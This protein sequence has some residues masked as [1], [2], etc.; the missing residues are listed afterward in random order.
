[1]RKRSFAARAVVGFVAAIAIA[2]TAA[3]APKNG[4]PDSRSG[5]IET[6]VEAAASVIWEG[7]LDQDAFPGGLSE[8]TE[9]IRTRDRNGDGNV[10][11]SIQAAANPRSHWFGVDFFTVIENNANA[12]NR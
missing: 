11:L 7:L 8:F 10:C 9:V 6:S 5:W 12:S 2:A 3:A 1:M 4:C